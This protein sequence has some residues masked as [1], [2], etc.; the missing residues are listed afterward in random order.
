MT[1]LTVGLVG[2]GDISTAYL[3]L[4]PRYRP[5]RIT[6]LADQL[7]EAAQRQAAAT[8]LPAMEVEAMLGSDVDIVLNLTPPAAH[9]ALTRRA[10]AAGKHVYSEKPFVLTAADGRELIS[11]ADAAGLRLGSAPDTFLGPAHQCARQVVETGAIGRIV[12]G[13]AAVMGPGMESWHPN[14]DFF[15]QPGG[16]CPAGLQ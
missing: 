15:F 4:A 1:P 11:L 12:T 14:P 8:G 3:A 7:P 16:T 2:C 10:L 5:F 13:T 6:A 9:A